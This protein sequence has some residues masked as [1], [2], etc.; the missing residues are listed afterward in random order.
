MN[1][2]AIRA[3][4]V[5]SLAFAIPFAIGQGF[6]GIDSDGG[7]GGFGSITF[8][9]QKPEKATQAQIIALVGKLGPGIYHRMSGC[10]PPPGWGTGSPADEAAMHLV[11]IGKAATPFVIELAKAQDEAT[12]ALVIEVLS[13]IKDERSIPLLIETCLED[14]SSR[15]RES[16]AEGLAYS[17]DK[18]VAPALIYALKDTNRRV[19]MYALQAITK[20]PQENA[21]GVL[22]ELMGHA[23]ESVPSIG[24]STSAAMVAQQAACALGAI[25]PKAFESITR[26]LDSPDPAVQ[27]VAQ[28]ALTNCNDRRAISKL[29]ELCSSPDDMTRLRAAHALARWPDPRSIATLTKLMRTGGGNS[30]GIAMQSLAQIGGVA[31]NPIFEAAH[32]KNPGWADAVAGCLMDIRDR[33]AAPRIVELLKSPNDRLRQMAM[34]HLATWSDP[35]AIPAAIH[36]A[37]DKDMEKR[38]LAIGSLG[39][40][41]DTDHPEIIIPLLKAMT[42]PHEWVRSQAA[43]AL[44]KKRDKR[45]PPAMKALLNSKVKDVPALAQMVLKQYHS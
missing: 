22:V 9:M 40:Y 30:A 25:G 16:A 15:V 38:R 45:I 1:V 24:P 27:A 43:G 36:D 41:N 37:A 42:D 12:R 31:L 6:G 35:H 39:Y 44:F 17:G 14:P 18:R 3:F 29:N 33:S 34:F 28:I 32:D 11:R 20:S 13:R 21:I 10:T 7:F 2:L 8:R 4:S 19:Q 23:A 5:L 26:L